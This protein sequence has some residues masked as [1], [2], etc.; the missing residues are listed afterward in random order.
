MF[1][2]LIAAA[3]LFSGQGIGHAHVPFWGEHLSRT[4]DTPASALRPGQW[5]WSPATAPQGPLLVVVNL[6]QQLAYV[7]RNGL[8][9][10]SAAVSSG[11]KGYE[12][13]TGV[14]H[15]LQKDRDHHSSL[16]HSAPMPYTQRLTWGGVA[17][18]A[19]GLPGYPSSHGCVHLPSEFAEKLFAASPLGMT[20]V[21]AR[22]VGT[23]VE[24]AHPM[25]ISP[26]NPAT[27]VVEHEPQLSAREDFRWEPEKAPTGPLSLV[28]SR[29]DRRLV[30][31]RAGLEIG[32]AR[33]SIADAQRPFGTHAFI[34]QLPASARGAPTF[35]SLRWTGIA[36][37][38]KG[39]DA[40][41]TL[42][43]DDLS[44]VRLPQG[45][46]AALLPELVSGTTLLVSD[47]PMLAQTT[48]AKLTLI[49][50]QPPEP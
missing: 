14:F 49:T 27:G 25:P 19:G 8:L 26:L 38:G 28:L 1:K 37:P 29:A 21:V 31:L 18:H 3:I 23:P 30:V 32:R 4:V 50:N 44:R 11:K 40:G 33:V 45:F 39:E 10:G 42:S 7:Y 12:T 20:V 17:L 43:A 15:T 6:D 22:G 13:P 36:V 46:L 34:V 2:K 16:Y 48:G 41:Q 5:M 47:A 9:I 35:Q 24:I